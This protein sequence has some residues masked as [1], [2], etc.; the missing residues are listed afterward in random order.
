MILVSLGDYMGVF[1][2]QTAGVADVEEALNG[3]VDKS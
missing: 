3:A 1:Q 2:Y